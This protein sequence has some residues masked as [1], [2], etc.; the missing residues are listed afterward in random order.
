MGD[1]LNL[2]KK[3]TGYKL[4]GMSV[5]LDVHHYL[6]LYSLAKGIAKAKLLKNMLDEWI[7]CQKVKDEDV[8]LLREIAQRAMIQ[9]KAAKTNGINRPL[10]EFKEILSKELLKK[11]LTEGEIKHILNEMR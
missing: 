9:W 5:H 6:T 3:R 7:R 2:Q 10:T 11:R 8:K 4:I 1:I